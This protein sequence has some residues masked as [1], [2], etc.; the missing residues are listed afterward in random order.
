MILVSLVIN[1]SFILWN[2]EK[3]FCKN[4]QYVRC[5]NVSNRINFNLHNASISCRWRLKP[6]YALIRNICF[7]CLGV[8]L[9]F[10]GRKLKFVITFVIF[11]IYLF[12]YERWGGLPIAL[13]DTIRNKYTFSLLVKVRIIYDLESQN[14]ISELSSK[15]GVRMK[16][17]S[18]INSNNSI[19]D[20]PS[21]TKVWKKEIL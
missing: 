7:R 15:I 1:L 2:E 20:A 5:W 3:K 11:C 18:P 10:L 13:I 17:S 16:Y 6:L 4:T 12:M 8:N 14:D 19:S 21:L 9:H